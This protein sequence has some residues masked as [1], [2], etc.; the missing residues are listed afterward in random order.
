M[1]PA[2]P[3]PWT[4]SDILTATGGML[5]GGPAANRF[6]AIG[7]DS[8][9]LQASDFFIAIKGDTHDGHRFAE[10]V[11]ASGG[12]GL[13]LAADAA[14][15]LP[16]PRWAEAG[17]A[18]IAVADTTRALGDLGA[19]HRRRL[20]VPVVA[21][22]GSNGKTTTRGMTA[23]VVSRRF[24]TLATIGNF[25]NQIGLPLTLL[26]L[27]AAHQWAVLE[28][29]MN[30]PG[31]IRRLAALCTPRIGV[32]TNV[33]AAHL[34][35]LG[36]LEAV[37]R[38]KGEL[39]AE[40]AADGIAVLNADDFRLMELAAETRRRVVRF[41]TAATAEVQARHLQ[42]AALGTTF[43][44]ILPGERA[45]VTLEVPGRFMVANALAAAAVGWTLGIGITEIKAGL[46]AFRPFTG[47]MA[48]RELTGGVHLI[49]DTYNANPGSMAAA[50]Q[51]LADLGRTSRRFLVIG[52]MLELGE[53][54]AALHAA[55]GELAAR[56]GVSALLVAGQFRAAVARGARAGG[57]Q[58]DRIFAGSREEILAALKKRLRPGDW[59]LVKGSRGMGMETI[60]Q[61]L[62]AWTGP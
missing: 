23:E 56:S 20:N 47:R 10:A 25:N 13:L 17:V 41:A 61:G 2:S 27:T 44:L 54:S 21:I 45:T 9:S 33:A 57:L 4:V 7:I 18:C 1:N 3:P 60:A 19:F 49:D 22:T 37:K 58:A 6:E 14:R 34:A 38:A 28:M 62:V 50:I 46:E 55:T 5:L 59:V 29:G 26:R 51:T 31:E 43:D 16:W 36:S 11:V 12:R 30:Q 52:D 53:Q 32:I 8:R 15:A 42:P 48:H 24:L 39:L 40:L 35:G